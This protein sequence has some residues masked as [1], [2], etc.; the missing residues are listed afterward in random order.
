MAMCALSAHRIK[1][2][3]SL[4]P[5]KVPDNFDPKLYLGEALLAI[6]ENLGDIRDF[7]AL[8]AISLVCLAAL[9][10]NNVP[11]LHK[12]LGLYHAAL[13]EQGFCDEKR[14]PRDI[15]TIEKE[16]RRRLFWHMYR[17]EVHTSLVMGHVVRCPELH[18]SVTYPTIPDNDPT[19][20]DVDTE[21]LSGWNF[22]TDL[23]RGI[24]HGIAHFKSRRGSSNIN[25]EHRNLSTSFILDYDPQEKI[26]GPLARARRNLPDRF[27]SASKVS[28]NVRRNRCGFQAANIACTY[29]V[30]LLGNEAVMS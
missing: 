23:Y 19:D 15:S 13:A 17:L 26:L 22:I 12:Y 30:S 1:S 6:P 9:H 7:Q 27:K 11:V 2:G 24:E 25:N 10:S 16:E 20:S 3:A 8:Q 14:W 29:Q 18:S 4:T 28:S 5:R 21:W